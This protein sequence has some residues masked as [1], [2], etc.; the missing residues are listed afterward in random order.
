MP[1]TLFVNISE[2]ES[3]KIVEVRAED[4]ASILET[5]HPSSLTSK[6]E[7]IPV[8]PNPTILPRSPGTAA[9]IFEEE[10][11]G[12]PFVPPAPIVS[13]EQQ[14]YETTS[15]KPSKAIM[16]P[17]Q[18][19]M[20]TPAETSYGRKIQENV[21]TIDQRL[22]ETLS[23]IQ[24]SS[25]PVECG[26]SHMAPSVYETN[27]NLLSVHGV[28]EI[29]DMMKLEGA[30]LFMLA[31]AFQTHPQLHLSSEDRSTE[32]LCYSYRV[33]L[34]ILNILATRSPSTITEAD[35]I[36]LAKHLKDAS[37]LGFDKDWL[38]SVRNRVSNCDASELHRMQQALKGL[39]NKLR[40]NKIELANIRDQEAK[41]AK[42]VEMTQKELEAKHKELE[43][44][45]KGLEA[46]QSH[47]NVAQQEHA[48]IRACYSQLL[49]ECQGISEQQYQY[50][51]II[52]AKFRPF[53]F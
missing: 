52:A 25:Q 44:A 38:E 53:G 36:L 30:E 49:E 32:L 10:E 14:A 20:C 8:S 16:S 45:Y 46:A 34:N 11:K 21:G 37:V 26:S 51:E 48:N 13:S 9:K 50:S 7:P 39:G 43:A 41:A 47:F 5:P 42:L 18:T 4:G 33:L 3:S 2:E 12:D 29:A 15:P 23:A 24:I 27:N 40:A 35:K 22:H 1:A 17:N 28:K 19:P 31:E 6:K